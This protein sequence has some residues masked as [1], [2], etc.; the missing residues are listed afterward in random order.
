[1]NDNQKEVLVFTGIALLLMLIFPPFHAQL[2]G[3]V[4]VGHGYGFIL[5]PPRRGARI[6]VGI[7]LIQWFFVAS[8][9][10]L[11]YRYFKD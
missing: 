3:G 9:G 7:L 2:S 1:M 6:D 5:N 11:A 8:I 4:S 10:G